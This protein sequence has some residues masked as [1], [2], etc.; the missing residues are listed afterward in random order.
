MK[1]R[2]VPIPGFEDYLIN[3]EGKVLSKKSNK[4]LKLQPDKSG[5]LRFT[6]YRN[7]KKHTLMVHQEVLRVFHGECPATFECRH[8]DGDKTNNCFWNLR[9][10]TKSNNMQDTVKHNV[11]PS[12][13]HKGENH[14]KAKLTAKEARE[15]YYLAWGPTSN[16]EI[17]NKFGIDP[18]TVSAIKLKRNWKSLWK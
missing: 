17:A 4:F 2:F 5:Y 13:T 9:W 18:D 3:D 10:D 16:K 14:Y 1:N 8:L 15:I 11:H 12:R 7:R 6:A